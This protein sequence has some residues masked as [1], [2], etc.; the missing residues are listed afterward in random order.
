MQVIR[1]HKEK[2]SHEE[3]VRRQWTQNCTDTRLYYYGARYFNPRESV[4]LSVD[5]PLID[6]TY[7][8]G[9]HNG[10]VYNSFNLNG[11]AYCYQNPVVL[12][13]PDGN[14]AHF[15]HGTGTWNASLYF[16]GEFK[17]KFEA[18]FGTFKSWEWSG[19][20]YNRDNAFWNR[21]EGRISAGRRIARDYI[22]PSIK[23]NIVNGKYIGPGI[24][25]GGHSH[26]GNVARVATKYVYDALSLM[27]EQGKL[28]KVPTLNLLM[29]NTPTMANDLAYQ[30]TPMQQLNINTIQVDS[31]VDIVAGAGQVATGNGALTNEFYS[32]TKHQ[33][34]YKDQLEF[35]MF[36][37][38]MSNHCGHADENVKVWYPLVEQVL[39]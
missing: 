11:Y 17:N 12:V 39:E 28:D 2:P 7:L 20:F 18:K 1:A 24:V 32:D 16:K 38:G 8:S 10:G 21:K 23:N 22:L 34:E 19:S 14:Q 26:G 30:L 33:I 29:V 36:G 35:D 4:W 6:G 9:K 27:V 3:K 37:C 25:I 15:M 13:D 31:K 5:K